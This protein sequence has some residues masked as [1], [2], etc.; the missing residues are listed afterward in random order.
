LETVDSL[1]KQIGLFRAGTAKIA[2]DSLLDKLGNGLQ[3]RDSLNLILIGTQRK[4][5][6]KDMLILDG[7]ELVRKYDIEG[8]WNQLLV[9][10][11]IHFAHDQTGYVKELFRNFPLMLLAMMPF[12]ALFMK[13]LYWRSNRYYVEHLVLN[14]HHHSFAFLILTM[15]SVLPKALTQILFLPIII[16]IFA[17]LYWT[18]KR[19]YGQGHGKTMLKFIAFNLYYLFSFLIVLSVTLVISLLL[20]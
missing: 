2:L 3:Q 18:M 16:A 12:L 17:Y 15:L 8:F 6:Y 9:R 1:S 10:Q 13:L 5:D 11:S 20:F 19:Y 14:F 7:K 4:F